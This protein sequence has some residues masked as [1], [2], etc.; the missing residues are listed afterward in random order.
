MLPFVLLRVAV[1]AVIVSAALPCVN[2]P[3]VLIVNVVPALDGPLI[4]VV[5]AAVSLMFALVAAFA[6]I[7]ATFV[8][9]PFANVV[10][11]IPP[12][13][14][15]NTRF[16]AFTTPVIFALSRLFWELSV[17]VP[18]GVTAFPIA[19]PTVNV[20]ACA[21]NV[22]VE[23]ALP[24]P[25]SIVAVVFRVPAFVATKLKLFSADDAPFIVTVPLALSLTNT[26]PFPAFAVT[27]ATLVA[28]GEAT[29]VPTVPFNDVRL[30]FVAFTTPV[31]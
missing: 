27:F 1:V 8:L 29:L 16:V 30:M 18:T 15:A 31:I 2:D 22:T 24:F 7:F 5:P 28:N 11:P 21:F 13:V 23:F 20:P 17:T 10:P 6:V 14:D 3:V 12:L 4:V 26:L 9:N 25:A 19:A